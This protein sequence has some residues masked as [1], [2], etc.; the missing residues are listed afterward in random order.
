MAGW[1]SEY[2]LA[3]TKPITRSPRLPPPP[4]AAP[5]YGKQIVGILVTIFLSVVATTVIYWTLWAIAYVFGSSLTIPKEEQANSDVSQ[6]GENAY[7][8]DVA[9]VAAVAPKEPEAAAP[10]A[11]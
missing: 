4:G 7:S 3:M 11:A 1:L 8:K 5:Q 10:T 9:L 2:G 6:H